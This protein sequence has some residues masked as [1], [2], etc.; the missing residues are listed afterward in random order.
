MKITLR[1]PIVFLGF[2]IA[3]VASGAAQRAANT[4]ASTAAN[5]AAATANIVAAAQAVLK[6]LDEAGRAKVQFPFDGPQ[7]TRWSNLPT[8][9]FERQGLRMGDLAAPQRAAVTALLQAALSPDGY[10]KVTEII[11]AE[12]VLRTAPRGGGPRGG[13]PRSEE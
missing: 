4:P 3:A 6:T 8:G 7:K 13:G 1:A 2:A 12:E 11:R 10:R 9:I 5:P